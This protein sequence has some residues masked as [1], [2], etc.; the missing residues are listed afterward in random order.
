MDKIVFKPG[1]I[2]ILAI[3]LCLFSNR[4]FSQEKPE[5][6]FKTLLVIGDDRSGSTSDIRKLEQSDYETLLQTVGEKGGGTVAVLLI[7]N[8]LPQSRQPYFLHLPTLENTTPYNPRDTKLTLTQKGAIKAKNDKIT[9]ANKKVLLANKQLLADFVNQKIKPNILTYK[10]AGT[11][12][13]DLGDALQRANV[14]IHEPQY[15]TYDK[16]IVA[17]ISD[18][19]DNSSDKAGSKSKVVELEKAEAYLVG[20]TTPT[21]CF[22]VKSTDLLSEKS[23]LLEIIKNLKK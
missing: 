5:P 19:I 11:D 14:I 4:A 20:W 3:G 10:P 12:H 2:K 21:D 22:R 8:P 18:G 15:K 13:T 7:G 9:E 23:S 16:I 17:F 1:W 6:Y